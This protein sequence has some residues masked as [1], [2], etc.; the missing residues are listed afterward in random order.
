MQRGAPRPGRS[1]SSILKATG[2]R[3]PRFKTRVKM[4]WDAKYFYIAA[5][6]EEPHVWGTLTPT[7]R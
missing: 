1:T 7:I 6:M 3:K 2:N 5:E 4:L